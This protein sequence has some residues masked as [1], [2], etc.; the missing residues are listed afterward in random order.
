M[1]IVELCISLGLNDCR[2]WWNRNLSQCVRVCVCVSACMRVCVCV[3]VVHE[4]MGMGT[5]V[6]VYMGKQKIMLSVLITLPYAF[7]AGCLTEL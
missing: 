7:E 3:C 4:Y 6:F 1:I 2:T 5:C